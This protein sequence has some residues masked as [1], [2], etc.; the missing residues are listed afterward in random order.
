MR[1]FTQTEMKRLF[2]KAGLKVVKTF[3]D[4][5]GSRYSPVA[6]PHLLVIAKIVER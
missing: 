5:D 1:L 6:S 4:Y 3:G 2:Q